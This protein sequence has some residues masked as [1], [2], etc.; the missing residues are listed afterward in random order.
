MGVVSVVVVTLGL[1]ACGTYK[2]L[3]P[4]ARSITATTT[5]PAGQCKTLANLTGKGGG[6]SGG[7]VSNEELV[8]YAV[9]DLRNQAAALHAPHVV[10]SSPTMGG[11]EGTTTSAMV[12]GEALRCEAG[13]APAAAPAP[14]PAPQVAVARGGCQFDSQCKGD[15]VCVN[16]QC[17]APVASPTSESANTAALAPGAAATAAAPTPGSAATPTAPAPGAAANAAAP[18]PGSAAAA[19][20]AGAAKRR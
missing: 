7:Y 20:A 17:V 10:Y 19:P 13:E 9:N 4:A 8:E 6:A 15:P 3:S 18:A 12:L 14:V 11:N 2:D 5:R 16:Q 1:P